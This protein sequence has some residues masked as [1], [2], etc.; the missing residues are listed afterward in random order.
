[1]SRGGGAFWPPSGFQS[2]TPRVQAPETWQL[3]VKLYE[4]SFGEKNFQLFYCFHV[5]ALLS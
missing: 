2:A 5:A 3:L 1:M 4:T